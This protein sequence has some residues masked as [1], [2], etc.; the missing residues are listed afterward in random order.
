MENNS[1]LN[2]K[3]LKVS[4]RNN[5]GFLQVIRGVDIELNEGEILGILGESG[6]G[7]TVTASTILRLIEDDTYRIDS[8][9]IVFNSK[10]LIGLN[11]KEMR[12]IRGRKISYVFPDPT[13][14]L[15]PYKNIV[16]VRKKLSRG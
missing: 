15:N 16:L 2:I 13:G 7:K 10:E 11:D 5:G 6:S 14:A 9:S 12:D 1:A 8:G 3:D 4:F